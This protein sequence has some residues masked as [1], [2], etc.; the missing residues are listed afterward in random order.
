MGNEHGRPQDDPAHGDGGD[1]SD[2]GRDSSSR[3]EG[4]VANGGTKKRKDKPSSQKGVSPTGDDDQDAGYESFLKKLDTSQLKH[5]YD[6]PIEKYYQVSD[7]ILGMGN[8]SVVKLGMNRDSGER[9]AVKIIDKSLLKNKPE[10]LTNEVDILLRVSHPNIIGL[11]DIFDTPDKCLLVM[12]LVTGGELFDRI[13][14]REQF[15]EREAKEVMKQLFSAISYL[16]A[17]GIVHRDLKPENLLLANEKEDVIKIADFGLSKIYS[18][19]MMSTA[20]GTPGYVAP[21]ILQC[22]GYSKQV[23]MW[24]CGVVMYILLCGY[25][26]FYN[27]N[28]AI[29][30]ETI[31][32][33]QFEF[34]SPY[35][36]SISNEA[37]DLIRRLLVVHPDKRL[38]AKQALKHEWF[39][40]KTSSSKKLHKNFHTELSRHNSRRKSAIAVTRQQSDLPADKGKDKSKDKKK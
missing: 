13:V 37:K 9:V 7:K 4:S 25:P 36:D 1:G 5:A 35:W 27:E 22:E 6:D 23:D 19:E 32:S 29:L 26:P 18:E 11:R 12:E 8:F 16:H 21:E 17:I 10:M 33:G 15:N 39:Q 38:T 40:T 24:S 14:E 2:A 20:C 31:M 3:R 28:D 30:F 34:H